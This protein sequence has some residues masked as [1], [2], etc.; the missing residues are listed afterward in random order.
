MR[1]RHYRAFLFMADE[2]LGRQQA[3]EIGREQGVLKTFFIKCL[4]RNKY[5]AKEERE[6]KRPFDGLAH[7]NDVSQI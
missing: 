5:R 2:G 4:I 6:R 7:F 1:R 3:D